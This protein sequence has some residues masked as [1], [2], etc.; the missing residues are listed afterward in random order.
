MLNPF[1]GRM[2]AVLRI[3]LIAGPLVVRGCLRVDASAKL[4]WV[5]DANT[6]LTDGIYALISTSCVSLVPSFH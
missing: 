1:A 6:V 4:A 2:Y 3:G 5:M